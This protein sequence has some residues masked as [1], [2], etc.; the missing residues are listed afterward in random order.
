[1][2]VSSGFDHLC[3]PEPRT[4]L[5]HSSQKSLLTNNSDD[6]KSNGTLLSSGYCHYRDK[7]ARTREETS[8]WPLANV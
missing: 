7:D 6:E 2:Y 8:H 4:V 5:D 3:A 1:M